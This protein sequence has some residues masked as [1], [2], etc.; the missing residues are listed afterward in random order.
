MIFDEKFW[1]A[2]AF[3][4]FVVAVI[5]F[6]APM[7]K[8]QLELKSRQI[9]QELLDAKEAKEEAKRL[10]L[11]AQKMYQEAMLSADKIIKDSASEAQ[12]FLQEA[13]AAANAE[14]A[15]KMSALETRIK[16]EEEQAIRE[17][18]LSVINAAIKKVQENLQVMQKNNSE[19]L[20]KKAVNDVSKIVH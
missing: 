18:K 14:M 11:A 9:A 17:I 4:G 16:S 1:L 3:L 5:K 8:N 15:K 6:V 7:I 13:Q 2:I 10:L 12:K 19:N 20:V